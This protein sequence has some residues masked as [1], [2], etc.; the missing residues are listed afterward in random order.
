[1]SDGAGKTVSVPVAPNQ[2]DQPSRPG[3][4]LGP[5]AGPPGGD[6][7]LADGSKPKIPPP[8]GLTIKDADGKETRVLPVG[9]AAGGK[10]V[11]PGPGLPGAPGAPGSKPGV[12]PAL[13]IRLS[14]DAH[15]LTTTFYHICGSTGPVGLGCASRC[16]QVAQRRQRWLGKEPQGRRCVEE[17]EGRSRYQDHAGDRAARS[18]QGSREEEGRGGKEEASAE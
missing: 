8:A 1:M 5:G 16:S 18:G 13:S 17:G 12:C 14:L 9:G 6:K 10:P 3:V 4:S 2:P 11:G 7:L 15:V